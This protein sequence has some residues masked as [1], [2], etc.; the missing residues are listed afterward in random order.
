MRK[1]FILIGL[2][3]LCVSGNALAVQDCNDV[4]QKKG[5]A[6]A[7]ATAG[8]GAAYQKC[9]YD[10]QEAL[11]KQQ[12]TA[13]KTI[14][15]RTKESVKARFDAQINQEEFSW[16]DVDLR[17]QI[18]EANRKLRIEQIAKDHEEQVQ[19]EKNLLSRLQKIRS[20]TSSVHSKKVS[21]LKK[22]KE[23]ELTDYDNAVTEY[24]LQMRRRQMPA[25]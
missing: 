10:E 4:Q 14:I 9:L 15:D 8:G 22:L 2:C 1:V 18:E 5:G 20:L 16:K 3:G 17:M 19:I 13:Y 7:V 11:L 24:E 21:R 6:T 25:L 12:L 23:A